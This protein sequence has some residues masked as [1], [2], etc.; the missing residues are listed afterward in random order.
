[1]DVDPG[2]LILRYRYTL[3]ELDTLLQGLKVRAESYDSNAEVEERVNTEEEEDEMSWEV[4]DF[5]LACLDDFQVVIPDLESCLGP[6]EK[7]QFRS[8][9]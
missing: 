7:G 2:S 9:Q 3:D 6:D 1:M 5:D 8:V 4:R